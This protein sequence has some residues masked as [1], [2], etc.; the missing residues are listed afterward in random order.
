MSEVSIV[1]LYAGERA[2]GNPVVERLQVIDAEDD[3]V[4]LLRSPAFIK[5][6]AKGDLIKLN[7]EDRAFELVKRSGNLC[8]RVFAREDIE[9]L[10]EDMT[11]L[12]EKLGGELDMETERML[13]YSIHVSCGFEKIEKILSDHVGEETE[14]AW[15]YGNVYDPADGVTPLNWWQDILKPQ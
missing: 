9:Q 10:A 11:P 14:S 7:R 8:I 13:V 1:E 2:D 3:G 15:L 5:G 12:I 4:V 6:L